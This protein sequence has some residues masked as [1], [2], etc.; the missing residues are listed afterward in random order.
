MDFQETVEQIKVIESEA[1]KKEPYFENVEL[2]RTIDFSPNE[3]IDKNY[4]DLLNNYERL[5]KIAKVT[6]VEFKLVTAQI[7]GEKNKEKVASAKP[8]KIKE[9]TLPTKILVTPE[10]LIKPL[11]I[12]K[13]HKGYVEE[14]K[15]KTA[16]KQ[17]EEKIEEVQKLNIPV[18]SLPLPVLPE[19]K[20]TEIEI[21]KK[22]VTKEETIKERFE[23][24][25]D[26]F[27]ASEAR[28]DIEERQ[29]A[30]S[31]IGKN[32][33]EERDEKPAEELQSP[34]TIKKPVF[35]Q[36]T[37]EVIGD[38]DESTEIPYFTKHSEVSL[39]IPSL[40]LV[41]PEQAA[42]EEYLRLEKEIPQI[43]EKI[44]EKHIKKEMI[45]LTQQLF[46]E[47]DTGQKE[48][49]KKQ[50]AKLK[51]ILTQK[52]ELPKRSI[53]HAMSFFNT[54]ESTQKM[55]IAAAKEK[56][57]AEYKGKL[58]D[59]SN[60]F[61][62]SLKLVR[63][64][65]EKKALY[66]TFIADLNTLESQVKIL[67]NKYESFFLKVYTLA[68][69]KLKKMALLND[70]KYVVEKI[71]QRQKEIAFIYPADF[72]AVED[73]VE[74]ELS[75]LAKIKKYEIFESRTDEELEKIISIINMGAEDLLNYMHT[76]H[77]SEYCKFEDGRITKFELL[78]QAKILM[79][80]ETGIKK[81]VL[82]KYFGEP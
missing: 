21:E 74:R 59:I 62:S 17:I 58:S 8:V 10:S 67:S 18:L 22:E 79:A 51:E 7:E 2:P 26:V 73:T 57:V 30:E 46:K 32:I 31:E 68:F 41:P 54:M 63:N 53:S 55:E 11:K 60:A 82:N 29:F 66:D 3:F 16:Q 70:D 40:L 76:N 38:I 1:K 9:L 43:E 35:S 23:F 49:I 39:A 81:E 19:R 13:E 5:V 75:S 28:K 6:N 52:H 25:K 45:S 61:S 34:S 24:E 42:E 69:E 72:L 64:N 48:I 44:D 50:I 4:Q 80:T 77:Q 15:N 56:I 65:E 27:A 78:N 37:K 12:S 47:K 71:E 20:T 33:E 14:H 36:E